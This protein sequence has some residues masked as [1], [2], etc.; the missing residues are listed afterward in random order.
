MVTG[1]HIKKYCYE[2]NHWNKNSEG[3]TKSQ[4]YDNAVLEVEVWERWKVQRENENLYHG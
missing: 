1:A 3:Q 4:G 2:K